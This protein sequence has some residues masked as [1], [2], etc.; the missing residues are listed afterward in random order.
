MV[1]NEAQDTQQRDRTC[2]SPQFWPTIAD[3]TATIDALK[4]QNKRAT[5]ALDQI[6]A[7]NEK[8]F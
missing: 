6:K 3:L 5:E 8:S 1:H 4:G 2:N 7:E